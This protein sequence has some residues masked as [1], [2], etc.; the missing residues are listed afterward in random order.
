MFTFGD[1]TLERDG[2]WDPRF[3]IFL[4]ERLTGPFSLHL[5]AVWAFNGRS[6]KAVSNPG[7]SVQAVRYFKQFLSHPASVVAGDFNASVI[8][9][10]PSGTKRFR[11]VDA[12]FREL[13]LVS[14]YH[15]SSGSELG[16]EAVSTHFHTSG[17]DFHIDY[18]YHP[19]SWTSGSPTMVGERSAWSHVSDH[20]PLQIEI[21]APAV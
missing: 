21:A 4:P 11:D 3:H 10:R 20:S 8:W 15:A 9:D 18:I 6:R 1:W 13:G 19:T 14:G 2:A 12:A 7:D 5:L 16:K 17:T